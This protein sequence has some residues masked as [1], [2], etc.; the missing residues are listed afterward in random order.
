MSRHPQPAAP[1]GVAQPTKHRTTPQI[2]TR[3]WPLQRW[4]QRRWLAWIV[5]RHPARSEHAF[6]QSSTY[7]LPTRAGW[8]LGLT[9]ALL[10]LASINF[11]LNLG[12][13]LTFWL[14]AA[15][16]A[17]V[18]Q[19]YRNLRGIRVR[20]GAL[21][22]VFAQ[23][24]AS[25]P[26]V[27][28]APGQRTRFALGLALHPLAQVLGQTRPAAA[29]AWSH[30]DLA[31][32]GSHTV[33]LTH[34]AQRRGWQ[35]LPRLQLQSHY[36]LGVFR[37]WSYWQP[38]ARLLVYP[39]PESPCPPLQQPDTQDSHAHS[40]PPQAH[41]GQQ[42][43]DSVR[44]YQRGDRL[45]DIAWKKSAPALAT[46]SGHL[47]VRSGQAAPP[48]QLWLEAHA[49]GLTET[50]AQIARLT[51]WVLHAHEQG[52]RWGLRLPSGHTLQPASG[53]AHLHD[54]LRA[55]ALDGQSASHK[56]YE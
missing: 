52:H 28:D 37:L 35:P 13:L 16:L 9:L 1:A 23:Q 43:Q 47:V 49:T 7:V 4:L 22:P 40:A 26:I 48:Q 51:A 33:T 20:V 34:T 53:A 5:R 21:E 18:W 12:Y 44:P 19:G 8:L 50:E 41:S 45:R 27:L 55:L 10:L 17:S 46:G 3:T 38:S 2:T 29:A 31:P 24:V 25:L 42:A 36:P 14:L 32:G 11:Q 30:T 15:A 56:K 54:C 6:T 39:A